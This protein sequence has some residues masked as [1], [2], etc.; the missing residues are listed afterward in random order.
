[1][2]ISRKNL[3]LFLKQLFAHNPLYKDAL[4]EIAVTLKEQ[5]SA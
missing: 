5:I 3:V 4:S 1:M 2:C